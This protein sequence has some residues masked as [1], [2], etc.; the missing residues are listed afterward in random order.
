MQGVFGA[1]STAQ[2]SGS[3]QAGHR[4]TELHEVAGDSFTVSDSLGRTMDYLSI[5]GTTGEFLPSS[6]LINLH[7]IHN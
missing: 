4:P 5:S 6:W 7:F 2:H 3:E 1:Q